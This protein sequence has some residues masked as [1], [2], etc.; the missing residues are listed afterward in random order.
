MLN[1]MKSLTSFEQ[2][3]T[4]NGV[5]CPLICYVMGFLVDDVECVDGLKEATS[6]ATGDQLRH[7]FTTILAH[8]E[9]SEPM[10][11]WHK[12]MY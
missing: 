1:I 11:V 5:I 2:I 10:K 12:M 8:Y 7:L 9:V 4:V 3:R 6:L